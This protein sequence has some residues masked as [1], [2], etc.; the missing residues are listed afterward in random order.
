MKKRIEIDYD[1]L[2]NKL[3]HDEVTYYATI[4]RNGYI[5]NVFTEKYN[6]LT[7]INVVSYTKEMTYKNGVT[8]IEFIPIAIGSGYEKLDIK[9]LENETISLINELYNWKQKR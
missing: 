9:T 7:L 8:E 5:Y 4:E 3:N 1:Y 6:N 2:V